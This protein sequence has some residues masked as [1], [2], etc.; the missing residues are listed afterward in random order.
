MNQ[1][2]NKAI[3]N[4]REK[5]EEILRKQKE[6]DLAFNRRVELENFKGTYLQI[7]K[8]KGDDKQSEDFHYGA[9]KGLNVLFHA[10][11]EEELYRMMEEFED[12]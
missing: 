4:Y 3:P 6:K 7:A 8:V 5:V 10:D 12:D 2:P 1:K 11:T 9:R